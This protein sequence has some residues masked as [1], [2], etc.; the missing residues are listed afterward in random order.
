LRE[1]D[2]VHSRLYKRDKLNLNEELG[3]KRLNLQET[4]LKQD[5][6]KPAQKKE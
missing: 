1:I 6:S 3:K 2:S 5:L 4:K